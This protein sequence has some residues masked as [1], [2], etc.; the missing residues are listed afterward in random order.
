VP[1]LEAFDG[2]VLWFLAERDENVPLV[3]T[4]VAL[5]RAF[6]AAP[7]DDHE[8]VVIEDAPH[9]FILDGPDGTPRYTDAFFS[10]MAQWMAK[11]GFTDR[12][13]WTKD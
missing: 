6:A 1:A 13:C 10:T 9:S 4:R 5:E 11:R 2:P 8:M 7:G 12:S 3:A